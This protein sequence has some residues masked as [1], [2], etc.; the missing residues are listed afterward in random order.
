[1]D[2]EETEIAANFAAINSYNGPLRFSS[3]FRL[4]LESAQSLILVVSII[5]TQTIK[6]HLSLHDFQ[7]WKGLE[8]NTIV[9]KADC[10]KLIS[11]QHAQLSLKYRFNL[12]TIYL[13][14]HFHTSNK[15]QICQIFEVPK[16]LSLIDLF[17]EIQS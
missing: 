9:M 13:Y 11:I 12:V 3:I 16:F 2:T 4:I 5:S 10:R 8:S 6:S 1:M 15:R 14:D 7:L 17:Q